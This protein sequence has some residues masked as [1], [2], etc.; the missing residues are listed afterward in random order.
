MKVITSPTV[1]VV[2]AT[3]FF[4]HPSYLIP[5]DGTD[6]ERLGAFAAKGC[7]DSY[8]ESGR[9]NL[10]NQRQVISNKHGS[11]LEHSM[12]SL[13]IEG[14]TRGC[15]LEF[16][17][18]RQFAISQ[19]STRYTKEEDSAIVLEPYYAELY[20]THRDKNEVPITSPLYYEYHLISEFLV[21]AK[22]AFDSYDK[23]IQY[24][25]L[26]NPNK[27]EGFELRKW[28]RGK[29]RNILPHGL[30][31]RGTWTGNHRAWRWFIELRSERHA[32]PEIRRLAHHVYCA[33]KSLAPVYYEDF[34][35]G[36]I[37]DGIPEYIV[38]HSKI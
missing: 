26:L 14:I 6:A 3:Q 22:A 4:G 37:V 13:F 18:H 38:G 36:D 17:R 2:A 27:L 29:A 24:L 23:Q 9:A 25:T 28:A 34:Q 15:S 31:T 16:N 35:V 1:T 20:A 30:E 21:V 7:Y 8:G 19:R 33:L 11:V 10:E 12:V 5:S 32:E